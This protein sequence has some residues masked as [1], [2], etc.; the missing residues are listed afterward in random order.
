MV[1][2]IAK[3]AV[4]VA[5][6]STITWEYKHQYTWPVLLLAWPRTAWHWNCIAFNGDTCL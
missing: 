1:I 6:H 5:Q 2:N 4:N 3:C